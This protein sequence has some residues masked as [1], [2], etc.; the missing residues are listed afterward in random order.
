[1][2]GAN[3]VADGAGAAAVGV[4][5][6]I[7]DGREELG[8]D[9]DGDAYGGLT[10]EVAPVDAVDVG[11]VLEA[12]VAEVRHRLTNSG[13]D[14]SVVGVELFMAG[15]RDTEREPFVGGGPV[16]EVFEGTGHIVGVSGLGRPSG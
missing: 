13:S 7:I 9:A 3:G 1:V 2:A 10:G 14:G 11:A 12:V 8:L 4:R 16:R 15:L 5:D 6:E